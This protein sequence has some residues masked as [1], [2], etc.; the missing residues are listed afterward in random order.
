M[1]TTVSGEEVGQSPETVVTNPNQDDSH[2]G[3]KEETVAVLK[4]VAVS[5]STPAPQVPSSSPEKAEVAEAPQEDGKAVVKTQEEGKT[6]AAPVQ[7]GAS[8]AGQTEAPSKASQES[9]EEK[10][11]VRSKRSAEAAPQTMEVEKVEVDKEKSEIHLVDG[12]N[13]SKKLIANRDGEK[14]EIAEITRDV[15]VN[16]NQEELE[17]T[18]KV[19][20]KE[21]DKGA[22][23]IVLLD[24]SK[25]MTEDAFN[26]AKENIKK[27]VTTLTGNNSNNGKE[28]PDHNNRNSVR[29]IDFYRHI[30]NPV[31]LSGKTAEQVDKILD[32]LRKKARNDY[33]GWGVDLQGAIHRARQAFNSN[34][35]KKSGKRQHIVLFSQGESTFSY[36]IRK[37]KEDLSKIQINE[38]VTYSNPLLPWPFYFDTTTRTHNIVNDA[39]QLIKFFNKLGITKFNNAVNGIAVT[40]NT[41]LGFGNL[42]GLKNPLDYITMADLDT[43]GLTEL[44]FNYDKQVGEGYNHRTYSDRKIDSVGMKN[45]IAEKIKQN[46]KKIQTSGTS[47]WLE[48]F[49]LKRI[50][51]KIQNWTID[52]ALDNLFYRRQYQ[53]YNHNLSA[54]AEA[55]MAQKEG[56]IF[57][58]FDVTMPN[59]KTRWKRVAAKSEVEKRNEKFDKYLEEMSEGGEFFKDVDQA[60]KFKDIL[61]EVKVTESFTDKV[62]VEPDSWKEKSN[63]G[64][65][66][67]SVKYIPASTN[68]GSLLSFF[69]T[70]S[71]TKESLSWTISKDSLQ[72]ALQSGAPL[73]LTYKLKV[74]KDNF[75]PDSKK[76]AKGSLETPD[77]SKAITAKVI[78]GKVTYKINDKEGTSKE[79]ADVNVTYSKETVPVPDIEEEIVIPNIPEK[80]LVEP[81][82]DS[83][84]PL[85]PSNPI[86]PAPELPD[87]EIPELENEPG[88]PSLPEMEQPDQDSPE[89]SGQSQIVDI[90]EDTLPGVSGQQSS[91]EETEITE[92]TRPE[93]DNEI[94]VGGQS[95]LVDIV[96]D[97]QSGMSG[98]H[99]SSEETEITEDTRP[100]SDN[101]IIVG[102]QSEL[103]DIVEDTQPSLSGHQSE[104][105]ETVT[106]E[107]TQ[108]NQTNILI[109]G[110]SEIVDIIEDTQAGMTGQYSSTD[111]LTIVED[112]LP[113]QMEETDEIKSDSQVMDIPKVNDTNNDKGA[114]ASVAFDVEESKVVS[115]QDIK[116]S[117]YVKDDNQL[118]QTGDDDKVN[119]FFTLAA[120]SVIG[121]AGLRQNKRREKER[122]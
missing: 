17:V 70:P 20:P 78:S 67:P 58:S 89:I 56:I 53:F 30:S 73:T 87:V 76:K 117:T 82:V 63:I 21:I 62:T 1:T 93:S 80:P 120:L 118:P 19:T 66:K 101:E 42:L 122:N 14:R 32:D 13:G 61:T 54:H 113:E 88:L 28:T 25:K 37:K 24:T 44:D 107:D 86:V 106:V 79:L 4:A 6:T 3:A 85:K 59:S 34:G 39:Q 38:P 72:K 60:E 57:R 9:P 11:R 95:E 81:D 46:I 116:P 43:K 27:L 52:K 90:V 49:G 103:V 41:F 104:S 50:S 5:A 94:I 23:V 83:I 33:N 121:A 7:A 109:G 12:E 111:Q 112:T 22:E 71:S 64:T 100:E 31:D 102:G 48:Y 47:N 98:Q 35:E 77:S 16:E 99:S 119:A 105:Q 92:D 51:E 15:K 2:S 65:E 115:T 45:T 75:K 8:T 55:Q 114:K 91:S 108:P 18:L 10:G 84:S 74:N 40:G 97:T 68:S 26:T 36:D 96:E 110:Q 29:L 69:F